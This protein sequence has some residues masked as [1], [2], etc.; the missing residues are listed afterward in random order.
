MAPLFEHLL[1]RAAQAQ[2]FDSVVEVLGAMRAAD[3]PVSPAVAQLV[4]SCACLPACL[5]CHPARMCQSC[6]AYAVDTCMRR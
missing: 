2:R 1:E 3:L 5:P 6:N 4:R